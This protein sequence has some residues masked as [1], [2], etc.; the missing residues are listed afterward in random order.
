M[1]SVAPDNDINHSVAIE[2][3]AYAHLL[4][5]LHLPVV[6]LHTRMRLAAYHTGVFVR[7]L[8][9]TLAAGLLTTPLRLQ[10]AVYLLFRFWGDGA[11]RS[12]AHDRLREVTCR[13][14]VIVELKRCLLLA[15]FANKSLVLDVQRFAGM[16]SD[17]RPARRPAVKKLA[18]N[19]GDKN[20]LA[21][22]T[23]YVKSLMLP[24]VMNFVQMISPAVM[25]AWSFASFCVTARS[26]LDT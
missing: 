20:H 15:K 7:L 16:P 5:L 26:S 10:A 25:K 2:V 19:I 9:K 12:A 21:P 6:V 1:P 24:C 22:I 8:A 17:P 13:A 14:N 11:A 4:Y 3:N 23:F 18:S